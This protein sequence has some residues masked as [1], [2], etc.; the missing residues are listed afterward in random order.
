MLSIYCWTNEDCSGDRPWDCAARNAWR[1]CALEACCTT[2]PVQGLL[3]Q[4]QDFLPP[5]NA[6]DLYT[7][8]PLVVVPEED[9]D[10][11]VMSHS[12][13]WPSLSI[14]VLSISKNVINLSNPREWQCHCIQ[15]TGCFAIRAVAR[16]ILCSRC[17]ACG[18]HQCNCA[19]CGRGV[20]LL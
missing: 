5:V 14:T 11:D 4:W 16:N 15:K 3:F 12:Y 10:E 17:C 18:L 19:S 1:L 7:W 20:G 9:H 8:F 13:P 2:I 6:D